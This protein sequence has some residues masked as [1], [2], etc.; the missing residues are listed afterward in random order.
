MLNEVEDWEQKIPPDPAAP[1]ELNFFEVTIA[2]VD[3]PKLLSRLSEA[4]VS[5]CVAEMSVACL[6][7]AMAEACVD[8]GRLGPQHLR[9]PCVQYQGQVLSGRV[10]GERL[11]E[12]G[13]PQVHA[14]SRAGSRRAAYA[15]AT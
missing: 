15:H 7:C 5:A 10:R 6:A 4:L 8:A 11:A 12:A 14:C 9:G 13:G 2:S 3:Q 1:S